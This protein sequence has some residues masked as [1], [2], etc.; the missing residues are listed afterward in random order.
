MSYPNG[1][2]VS[3][4]ERGAKLR[5]SAGIAPSRVVFND[6]LSEMEL[7]R[8]GDSSRPKADVAVTKEL[9]APSS[10]QAPDCDCDCIFPVPT[11]ARADTGKA[12]VQCSMT[13][14][15][16]AGGSMLGISTRGHTRAAPAAHATQ[17]VQSHQAGDA[18]VAGHDARSTNSAWMRGAP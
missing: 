11:A 12:I 1:G 8:V 10:R 15:E 7:P 3:N 5:W 2:R 6:G 18:A 9:Y 13:L 17:A 14:H 16:I 4:V